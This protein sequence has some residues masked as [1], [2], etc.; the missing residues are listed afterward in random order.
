MNLT[1]TSIEL[2]PT[3]TSDEI[4][5]ALDITKKRAFFTL[6]FGGT[7]RGKTLTASHWANRNGATMVRCRTG[8]TKAK[9]L[10]Q[11]S[12]SIT[13]VV[14]NNADDREERIIETLMKT[15]KHTIII[16]EANHLLRAASSMTRANSLDFIR[17]IYDEMREVNDNPVGI[18]LIFTSYTFA[19]FNHGSM[20]A[21]LEQ[22]AG[23]MGHHVQIPDKILVK[24]DILPILKA[25]V[26]EPDEKLLKAAY[27]IAAGANGKIRTL[28]KYLSLA[29]EYVEDHK[30]TINAALLENLR[31]RYESGGLWPEE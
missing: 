28:V 9:I 15:E 4:W 18:A 23:R 26:S 22:F 10:K 5:K 6:I 30:G 29:K 21:F 3:F 17:D 24:K 31:V 20:A 1:K 16:D 2:V 14:G 25:Y 19:E 12:M 11:L 8:A 13:G 7:G 27:E